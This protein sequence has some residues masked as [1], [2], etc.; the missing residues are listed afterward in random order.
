MMAMARLLATLQD[1]VG[2]VAVDGVSRFEW[3]GGD[4][5][6]ADFTASAD[7]LDGVQLV[8]DR[9]SG[10]RCGRSRPFR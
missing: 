4:L 5:S 7:L 1:D 8:G 10:Q 9:P 2:N 3:T 6:A